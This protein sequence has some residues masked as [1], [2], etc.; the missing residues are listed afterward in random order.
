MAFGRLTTDKVKIGALAGLTGGVIIWIYEAL[1]WV[2]VQ[3]TMPLAGIPRNATGLVFGKAVQVGLGP[4]ANAIGTCIHFGF[5]I[6][7]GV[8]FAFIWP[9]F[10]KRGVEATLVALGYAV[11]AWIVMHLAIAAVG[12]NHPDYT[13]PVVI[14]GGL[15]SH[16]FFTVPLALMVKSLDRSAA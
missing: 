7:W 4:L 10:Q 6:V 3:H 2:G 15:M 9:F 12:E 14:I 1:V 16:F 5:A 13:D 8:L 11:V